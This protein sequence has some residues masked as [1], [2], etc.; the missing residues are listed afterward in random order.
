MYKKKNIITFFQ[1]EE[2]KVEK[3]ITRRI[4][5]HHQEA[6]LMIKIPNPPKRVLI[7]QDL[8]RRTKRPN[9]RQM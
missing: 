2:E 9:R 7:D 4:L 5:A 6:D 3:I 8:D 1:I